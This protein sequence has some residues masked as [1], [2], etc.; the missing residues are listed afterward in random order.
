MQVTLAEFNLFSEVF[1]EKV[2][3][4]PE[5]YKDASFT[6]KANVSIDENNQVV[7]SI[8]S[9]SLTKIEALR[10]GDLGVLLA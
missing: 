8:D 6:L 4:E 5:K 1:A 9:K 2:L 7:L 10:D 3:A